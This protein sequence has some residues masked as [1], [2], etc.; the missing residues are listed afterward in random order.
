MKF[1]ISL[2]FLLFTLLNPTS[3]TFVV[4]CYSRL[5]DQRA[6]PIIS[7]GVAADHVHAI[8]GA[9]GFNFTT[10]YAKLRASS[11]STCN[12][13]QDMS[14]YWTPKLYFKAQNGSF[15][16]VPIIG[17]NAGGNLG[18]MAI[19]YLTRG[20]PDNDKLRAFP[21]GFRMVAGDASKRVE[22]DDFAGRAVTHKCVGVDGPDS[23]G[24]PRTKCDTIRAQVTFPSCW[25]GKNLDSA[26]HKSH[27]AYPRDGN[28]DGGR[29]PSSHPI[30]LATLFYEVYYDTKAFK[31]MWYGG[32]KQQPFVFANGDA[33][34]YGFHGDFANGWEANSLQKALDRCKDGVANCEKEVF[35]EFRSQ[36]EAQSCKLPSMIDEQVT[37]VLSA[38]PG[39]N[40]VTY[41]PAPAQSKANCAAPKLSLKASPKSLG[42]VDVTKSKGYRYIGCG[43]DNAGKR[44]LSQ[45]QTSSSSMMVEKCID[46]CKSKGAQYAGL[47]YAG[48]CYCG[49]SLAAD[50]APVQGRLGNCL[51]KCSG[52]NQQVCGGAA[53]ISLY[54]ACKGATCSNLARRESQRLA[55]LE[56]SNADRGSEL[57]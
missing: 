55:V 21:P 29:C 36:G 25:D 22:T 5:F 2:P 37:G 9:N 7:P 18:G 30:H 16:D 14:V 32:D 38:L 20:G 26:N 49:A 41:G 39:C 3:A 42:Y 54:Q 45:A 13:K 1:N 15:I 56:L 50:R 6:D 23:K 24:L 44:T 8:S 12:I 34:G 40:S 57:R 33:T 28:Y 27:V 47:E 52:N 17:D 35:G 48:E 4:Q 53:A 43:T 31:G 46:F 10:D 19:Y 51:M 11:C